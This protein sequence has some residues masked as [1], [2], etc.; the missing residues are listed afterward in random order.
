MSLHWSDGNLHALRAYQ[1]K[2]DADDA[3]IE[4]FEDKA[5]E[6]LLDEALDDFDIT[7]DAIGQIAH[8]NP[9]ARVLAHATSEAVTDGQLDAI[10]QFIANLCWTQP[11]IYGHRIASF[12]CVLRDELLS[13]QNA[14][15]ERAR[16]I[17]QSNAEADY[18]GRGDY[19]YGEAV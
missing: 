18:Y 19:L 1:A 13:D 15:D 3:L 12:M 14:I 5:R 16:K 10:H 17:G 6:Q 7:L 11:A 9:L 8:R 2:Q 4:A